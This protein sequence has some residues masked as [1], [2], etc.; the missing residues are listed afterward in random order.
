MLKNKI[1]YLA[2]ALSLFACQQQP[3][4]PAAT[5]HTQKA[6][7]KVYYPGKGD[8]WE[9]KQ[10][11]QLGMDAALLQEAVDWARQQ[12]TTQMSRDFSTQ[13]EIFGRMLGPIP[14][15]RASTNGIILK[16]GYIVAEW[17]ETDR[18]DPTYSVA[19]SV[20]STILGITID[21]GMI[22][23]I[24]DPV[25]AYVQDG[26][27]DSE[28]NRK[29]TWEHHARQTSEWEGDMWG[30][31]HDF[32]GKKEYGKGERKPRELQEPGTF[33]EYNDVRINR[34]ALSLLRLWKKP[35]PEVFKEEVMD[36][37]DASDSWQYVPYRNSYVEIDGKRM[38]SV[39]GGTRWGGGLWISARD[40]ARFGY[41][42]LRNGRW[43]DKQI[44]SEKWVKEATTKRGPVGPD[45]GYLW[46][47]NTEGKAWPS[48]PTTSYAALG[49]GQNTIWVDPE[50]DIVI[51]WRW[52][53]GNP[54][55]L[56]KRVLAAVKE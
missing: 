29:V 37:I 36:P 15:D 16:N 32:V 46:W 44:V 12:E 23:D 21:R 26:G 6:E 10:P 48:A 17:G 51:V 14:N 35:I 5:T 27:Y 56:I 9:K 38:P 43:E 19:K 11:G 55:E 52:H 13:E 47:L 28:Q 34:F 45:Y 42:F 30:K 20:L 7:T 54:D 50:H 18:V 22:K 3:Q 1:L 40:E 33:Y 2:L 25:T 53:N 39:S 31:K 49:A 8:K 41:L 24:Q 4:Q